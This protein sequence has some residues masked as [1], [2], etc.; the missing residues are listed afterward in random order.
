[1]IKN[2]CWAGPAPAMPVVIVVLILSHNGVRIQAV[3]KSLRT[4]YRVVQC[5]MGAKGI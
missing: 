1:M 4:A 2:S 5:T 3:P